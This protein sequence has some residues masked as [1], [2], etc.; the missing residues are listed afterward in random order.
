MVLMEIAK[1]KRKEFGQTLKKY[2][3]AIHGEGCFEIRFISEDGYSPTFS[4][5]IT[6]ENVFSLNSKGERIA[7]CTTDVDSFSEYINECLLSAGHTGVFYTVNSPNFDL[8]DGCTVTDKS[9]VNGGHINAQ[10]VDIDAPKDIRNSKEKLIAW[11]KEVKQQL[12]AFPLRPSIVV[13]SKNGYHAYWL[14]N[15]G[16]VKDFRYIQLQL[17]KYFNGDKQ[18]INE[19]RL[20]RL[21]FFK[22]YKD[23]ND[24]YMVL[25]KIFQ[26]NRKY[27]QLELKEHLPP[28]LAEELPNDTSTYF[29]NNYE[30]LGNTK[31]EQTFNFLHN[32]L[33]SLITRE[34]NEK[35]I[36][37]CCMPHH[38]DKKPSAWISKT[39]L[40]YHC[41]G[42]NAKMSLY[43]LAQELQWEELI[44]ILNSEDFTLE[45]EVIDVLEGIQKSVISV[46]DLNLN[47]TSSDKLFINQV[48][49][50][51]Y[52]ELRS[53]G[54]SINKLHKK[55]IYDIVQILH[56]AYKDKPYLIPL[57]MGGGKSL[58][59]KIY[60]REA[61]N[62]NKNSGA[63][64]VVE[65]VKD[66]IKLQDYFNRQS[67]NDVALA[68]YGF[69]PNECA[70]NK[71]KNT[72]YTKCIQ[73]IKNNCPFTN[74][75]RFHNQLYDMSQYPIIII[76]T[77]RLSLLNSSLNNYKD[78]YVNEH[79][80]SREL[81][82]IDEKPL[83]HN[84]YSYTYDTFLNHSNEIREGLEDIFNCENPVL[85]EF[86]A[87]FNIVN[88]AFNSDEKSRVFLPPLNSA[89]TFS[90]EFNKRF[91]NSFDYS[92]S[93][94]SLKEF[95]ESI[96]KYGGHRNNYNSEKCSLTTAH[97]I[98][99][100]VF[101]NFKTIIFD[102]TA[103]IDMDYIHENYHMLD[104][105]PLRQYDSLQFHLQ[106]NLSSSK[107]SLKRVIKSLCNDVKSVAKSHSNSYIYF[108]V[109]KQ[110]YNEIISEFENTQFYNQIKFASFGSTKGSNDFNTCD[111]VVLGGIL[112][113]GE[114]Y[115]IA[116]S[117]LIYSLNDTSISSLQ[118]SNIKNKRR[119]N[120]NKIEVYKIISTL[121]DYTQEIKRSNQR[122]NSTAMSCNIYI[123]DNDPIFLNLLTSVCFPK[124]QRM[125][126]YPQKL[127]S[128][129]IYNQTNNDKIQ[130]L[131]NY[132]EAN[133]D[134][135]MIPFQEIKEALKITNKQQFSNL[136]KNHN[137]MAFYSSLHFEVK[138]H[139]D[140]KRTK[141]LQKIH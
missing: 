28:L 131:C 110:F 108:P 4:L 130:G 43:S 141:I 128:S 119:F 63:I 3:E 17:V 35:I 60:L 139:P 79:K 107:T 111:V 37:R 38:N 95:I 67:N 75:C 85:D 132:L 52:S 101:K 65:R 124:S 80:Y 41:S 103:L 97:L 120:D 1:E 59:I 49:E 30:K 2:L 125:E 133:K 72:N 22:H 136:M 109:Y 44:E 76:T 47:L 96:I 104:L 71:N 87:A 39:S 6:K 84:I 138:K 58:I 106:D 13:D 102:G 33:N 46:N 122:N 55:S 121:V 25:P 23:I 56:V 66:A 100:S 36:L 61:I 62:T 74:S 134:R 114:D 7:V 81:L 16:E 50:M 135:L 5:L 112:H 15:N 54:Q 127:I 51:V 98:K 129:K 77:K 32:Q 137:V 48:S 126:W 14:L 116:K 78:F 91:S 31:R 45:D 18:C 9:I 70:L 94:F 88:S 42:C 93:V 73:Q 115:Y 34:T 19:S 68:I 26:P 10:F 86:N 118:C 64:V 40:F 57:E 113:K 20:L 90:D 29:L 24:P 105:K 8:V 92:D 117:H 21:P 27:T 99:Y 82:I 69:N 83:L 11:K 53:Y 140:N 89:F 123:F 12:L